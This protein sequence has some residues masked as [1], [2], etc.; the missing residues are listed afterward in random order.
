M[1]DNV[2]F[3]NTR[4]K[5]LCELQ[6]NLSSKPMSG[7]THFC[8]SFL[9]FR[10]CWQVQLLGGC[11]SKNESGFCSWVLAHQLLANAISWRKTFN[12]T[13]IDFYRFHS[14][15]HDL[16]FITFRRKLACGRSCGAR[17]A[18]QTTQMGVFR[19]TTFSHSAHK[20]ICMKEEARLVFRCKT[21]RHKLILE[22]KV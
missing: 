3:K 12:C 1:N 4:S 17:G 6:C 5:N 2:Q 10:S 7:E 14:H 8:G 18:S 9:M 11:P 22:R 13:N 15:C 20:P 21:W 19:G 16:R